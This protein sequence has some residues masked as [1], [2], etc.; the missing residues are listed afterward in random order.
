M[1]NNGREEFSPIVVA[2]TVIRA[3]DLVRRLEARR[4]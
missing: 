4:L 1:S 2:R 3:A